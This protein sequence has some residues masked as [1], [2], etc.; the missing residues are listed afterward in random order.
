MWISG[1]NGDKLI[2][3]NRIYIWKTADCKGDERVIVQ[4]CSVSFDCD[5]YETLGKYKD[6]PRCKEVLIDIQNFI[7]FN[8]SIS[9]N[10]VYIMPKE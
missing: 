3:C 4:Q 5:D 2:D 8:N 7:C 6:E 9:K 1:Q 10:V